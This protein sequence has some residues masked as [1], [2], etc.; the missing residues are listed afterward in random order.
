MQEVNNGYDRRRAQHEVAA[1]AAIEL[2]VGHSLTDVEWAAT[3]AR[4]A[5]FVSILRAWEREK[6]VAP[7]R[8]NVEVL[9][10]RKP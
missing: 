7:R 9:C 4:L 8:G 3:R 10:E 6:M 1:R 2:R 5:D